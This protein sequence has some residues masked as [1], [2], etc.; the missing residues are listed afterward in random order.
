MNTDKEILEGKIW[1]AILVFFFPILLGTFFQQLYNTVDAVI[2][3]RFAGKTALSSVGGSSAIIINLVVGFF[4]GLSTGCTVLIANYFGAKEA[5]KLDEVLHTTYAFGITGGILL[6]A[7]LVYIVPKMLRLMKTDTALMPEST[8]YLRIYFAGLIFVFIYNLG[9]GILR[10]LGDSRRPLWYLIVCTVINIVFDLVFVLAL[11]WGVFGVALATLLAQAV[12]AVLVTVRLC[13]GKEGVTLQLRKI[14]FCGKPF[15]RI[16]KIGLPAG[17]QS[18]C[19]AISNLFIQTA[20]NTFGVN[21]VAGWTAEGKVDCIFWMI[22]A[23]F[24]VAA[25]TFVGQNYGAGNY[26]RVRKGT[27]VCLAMSLTTAIFVSTVLYTVGGYILRL[28]SKD[29]DVLRIGA[30]MLR[31]MVPA[32]AI[33]VFIEIFSASLRARGDTLIPTVINLATIVGFRLV[34]I[35]HYSGTTDI[36]KILWCYPISW[37]ICAVLITGYYLFYNMRERKKRAVA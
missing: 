26:D 37:I 14:R 30:D 33:F 29:T 6:G 21:T 3:G 11:G 20:I 12:S 18:S 17:I 15:A 8:T 10:A 36:Y 7:P 13:S 27:R 22:N 34:W 23:S 1:K 2:V 4:T 35:N 32:Y 16:I 5:K 9:S 24:G 31:F 19:Y 28:F 25:T